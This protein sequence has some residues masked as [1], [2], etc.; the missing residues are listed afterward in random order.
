MFE[1][2]KAIIFVI[3]WIETIGRYYQYRDELKKYLEQ[4]GI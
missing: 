2:I 4:K 1:R 3:L